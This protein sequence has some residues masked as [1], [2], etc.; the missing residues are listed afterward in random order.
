MSHTENLVIVPGIQ[1]LQSFLRR[2]ALPLVPAVHAGA[3]DSGSVLVVV[4][5]REH[6]YLQTKLTH[7]VWLNAQKWLSK[8]SQFGLVCILAEPS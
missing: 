2:E 4:S 8:R 6:G 7:H 3:C 5:D 1:L